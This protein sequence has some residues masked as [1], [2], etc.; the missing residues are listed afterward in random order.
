MDPQFVP[1]DIAACYGADSISQTISDGTWSLWAP[2]RLRRGPSHLAIL[3]DDSTEGS[4]WVESTS[5]CPH[6]CL[7][8][9]LHVGGV[10]A[11]RPLDRLADYEEIGG[12]IDFYRLNPLKPLKN[13]E[14][15]PLTSL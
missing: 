6:P 12:R 8:R 11:Q 13:G 2:S 4:I 14:A 10:Q 5:T 7:F 15:A 3:C 1:G 9:K